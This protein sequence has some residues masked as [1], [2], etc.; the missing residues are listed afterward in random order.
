MQC[1]L[2]DTYK[3]VKEL[4]RAEIYLQTYEEEVGARVKFRLPT[5]MVKSPNGCILVYEKVKG[6]L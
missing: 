5:A 6:I 2:N 1:D 3:E 4:Y